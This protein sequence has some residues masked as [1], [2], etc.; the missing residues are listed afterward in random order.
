M[1]FTYSDIEKQNSLFF[2][3]IDKYLNSEKLKGILE[4][5]F[6]S[7]KQYKKFKLN[8]LEIK[9]PI[10]KKKIEI[11]YKDGKKSRKSRK[12]RNII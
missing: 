5:T 9:E 2:K 12:S 1:T 4:F 8:E 11:I 7:G 6:N 3:E 10:E